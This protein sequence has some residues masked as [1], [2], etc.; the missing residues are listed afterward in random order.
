MTLHMSQIKVL[1]YSL[2]QL[3]LWPVL[4][5]TLGVC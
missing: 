2:T 3:H 4:D 1:K 5:N